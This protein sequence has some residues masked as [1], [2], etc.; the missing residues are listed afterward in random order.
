MP[1][2]RMPPGEVL[3]LFSEGYEPLQVQQIY[4]LTEAVL[5]KDIDNL[6]DTGNIPVCIPES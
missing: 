6:S 3:D 1:F 2:Y 4:E 5:E